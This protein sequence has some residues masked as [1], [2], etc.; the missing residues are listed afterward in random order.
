MGKTAL[1]SGIPPFALAAFRMIGG[2]V[3]FWILSLFLPK[4]KIT[5]KDAI[6][7]F[8]AALMGIVLNQGSFIIGLSYT[9]PVNASI[10]TTT[11]P[12]F[13]M[14]LA[15]VFLREP[16][17]WLKVLGVAMGAGGAVML[18]T[19]GVSLGAGSSIKGDLLCLSAQVLFSL[20]LSL[21]KGLVQRYNVVTVM[22][23]MFLYAMIVSVPV[24]YK[25]I[26]SID[27]ASLSL[28]VILE[29]L[30]VVICGTFLAYIFMIYGQQRLRPTLVSMYNYV[31]PVVATVISLAMGIGTFGWVKGIAVALVFS[32]VYMVTRSRSRVEK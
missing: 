21:F 23:W 31:Q 19:D 4:E 7:F 6:L 12:I 24:A 18:I 5:A 17:T 2:A 27:Y 11:T 28:P 13:T 15:A 9:S 22:K 3:C 16:I 30:Y 10:I 14:I 20:Y 26:M 1:A 32:G 8:P 29:V 25:D